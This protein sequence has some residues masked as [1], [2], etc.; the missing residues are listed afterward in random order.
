MEICGSHFW[1]NIHPNGVGCIQMHVFD[2]QAHQGDCK[3]NPVVRVNQRHAA[4]S[5]IINN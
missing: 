3:D 2:S 1:M 4:W 5:S